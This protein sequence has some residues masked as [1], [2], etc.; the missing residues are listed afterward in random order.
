MDAACAGTARARSRLLGSLCS[1]LLATGL[2]ACGGGETAAPVGVADST[3]APAR[4]V[5]AEGEVMRVRP[6]PRSVR[7][8]ASNCAG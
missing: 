3:P 5:I 4:L 1:L 7:R 2:A 6:A 8:G